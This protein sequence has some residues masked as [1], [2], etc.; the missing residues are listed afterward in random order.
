MLQNAGSKRQW[1]SGKENV[2]IE[3]KTKE[4]QSVPAA[5]SRSGKLRS[6]WARIQCI[7]LLHRHRLRRKT[8][9]HLSRL[10]QKLGQN[11]VA[12][13]LGEALYALGFSTEY[14]FVRAGR[15]AKK[16][17]RKLLELGRE[18]F[19]NLFSMAFPGAKTVLWELFGP[20]ILLVRGTY[21][22]IRHANDTRRQKGVWASVKESVRFLIHGVGKN[23][24]TLPRMAMYLLPAAALGVMF[25]VC[26]YTL[27]Q[28]Y[29]LE[30]QVE[31]Q[32]VGYI[33]NEAV[34]N[35]ALETVQERISY[36]GTDKTEWSVEPTYAIAI[37]QQELMDENDM[38]NAILK[39][40]SD[41]IA[42]GIALYLDGELTA[43]CADGAALQ[44]YLSS[45]VEPYEDPEDPNTSVSFN[46]EVELENGLYFKES[47]QDYE[48]VEEMLSG[49][50]QAQRIYTIEAGDTLW[51][52][53]Q[54]NDLT[55]KELCALNP[56]FKG[57]PLNEKSSIKAGDELIVTKQESMLEVRIT[58]IVTWEE[59]IPY[60]TVSEKSGDLLKGQKKT[61]QNGVNGV[62]SV[63][64]E[65][66][67]DANG[68][69]L[70][71]QIIGTEVVKE[72]VNQK[73]QIGTKI[74]Y[75]SGSGQFIWPVP[76]YR[77]V[78]RWYGGSH[79]G[80]DITGALGTPI[81]ASAAGTVTKAG[82][83]RAGAGTNYGYSIILD[84]GNGYTTIYAHC[85][86]LVVSAG[87]YV[88]Q[89]QLVGYMGSTGRSTGVHLHF[90]IR[91]NGSYIP[92][93][94]VFDQSKY[95][96]K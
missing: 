54:K 85:T 78:S 18:F 44:S 71:Q 37:S 91:K 67:Y 73:I 56:D 23:I 63:T 89:G 86:S 59:E 47:F 16:A 33:A 66:V 42:E 32:P 2:L 35:S 75:I 52:I 58:K 49:V 20:I 3:E 11:P 61:V 15:T 90:E 72:P 9:G 76:N 1:N 96:T 48:D 69:Q 51:G 17:A 45:L 57:E 62:R 38:A 39:G 4:E 70:S 53:A 21:G 7:H 93:Q 10:L 36:A 26:K 6:L 68:I 88:K 31:G 79:R 19:V 30:V 27:E 87:E 81:Y 60:S 83:N 22:L 41:E 84:H 95:R 28:P 8:Q 29:A 25:T 82:Y 43:V 94:S 46:K 65:R 34:F 50:Q 12:V 74:S 13:R 40:A 77:R 64:A 24:G 55:F 92:P 80:V 5:Q 14:V